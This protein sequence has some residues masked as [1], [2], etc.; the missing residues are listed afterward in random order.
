MDN[1]MIWQAIGAIGM[2]AVAIAG[3]V[4]GYVLKHIHDCLHRIEDRLAE[5]VDTI[6][7][8]LE[9]QEESTSAV[10]Q[11]LKMPPLPR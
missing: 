9:R 7:P 4:I 1:P 11:E 6:Y 10:R 8:R 5:H 3:A 2:V